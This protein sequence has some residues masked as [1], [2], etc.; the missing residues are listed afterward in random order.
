MDVSTRLRPAVSPHVVPCVV[1]RSWACAHVCWGSRS[2]RGGIWALQ[3]QM[4]QARP[5]S[6]SLSGVVSLAS[7][8][9]LQPVSIP[10]GAGG[11]QDG[12]QE[13]LLRKAG[14]DLV[15]TMVALEQRTA[16]SL[17]VTASTTPVCM[18]G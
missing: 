14:Q 16:T 3:R 7:P 1:V 5:L 2:S 8:R 12:E 11:F 9:H 10:A 15:A 13:G 18:C 17:A 4:M 6:R